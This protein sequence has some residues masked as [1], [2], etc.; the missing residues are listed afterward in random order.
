[1]SSLKRLTLVMTAVAMM[2]IPCQAESE[3]P[4]ADSSSTMTDPSQPDFSVVTQPQSIQPVFPPEPPAELP[5]KTEVPAEVPVRMEEQIQ[6]PVEV[7]V[8][9]ESAAELQPEIL[10]KVTPTVEAPA[11]EAPPAPSE[12][13]QEE[14]QPQFPANPIITGEPPPV[15]KKTR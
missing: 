9:I 5:A 7:P 10:P 2:T 11:P 1:M 14:I 3:W 15:Q 12:A 6:A 13:V 4:Q 8:P